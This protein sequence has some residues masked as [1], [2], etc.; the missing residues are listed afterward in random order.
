MFGKKGIACEP[1]HGGAYVNFPSAPPAYRAASCDQTLETLF[2]SAVTHAE[3][4]IKWYDLSSGARARIGKRLRFWA[5]ILFGL[6]TAAPVVV[7]VFAP[8]LTPLLKWI[9]IHILLGST[10]V[11]ITT[12]AADLGYVMLA[13]AGGLVVF[14]QFFDVSGSWIRFR[15]AQARL[16]VLLAQ[17]RYDWAALL[18]TQGGA[19]SDNVV[20]AAYVQVLRNFVVGVEEAAEIETREWATQFR[21]RIEAFDRKVEAKDQT[22]NGAPPPSPGGPVPGGSPLPTP[23]ADPHAAAGARINV[24]LVIDDAAALSDLGVS[25]NGAAIAIPA[26]GMTEV[27]LEIGKLHVIA[28]KA[29]RAGVAVTGEA[30]LTPSRDDELTPILLALA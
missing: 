8:L 10:D 6:G 12:S 5:L 21:A 14:D 18:A 25:V 13:A 17:F 30:K 1:L 3:D 20:I 24:R 27:S 7:P 4:R 28:A 19:V 22:T 23:N 26:D 11:K 16:E 2:R 15:Q 29:L 9:W